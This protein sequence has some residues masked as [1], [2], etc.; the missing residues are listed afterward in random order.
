MFKLNIKSFSFIFSAMALILCL[1]NLMGYDD[2]NK[3]LLYCSPPLWLFKAGW[4]SD[5]IGSYKEMPLLLKYALTFTFWSL[6]G[7]RIDKAKKG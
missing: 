1:V 4:F 5:A 6:V 3:F 7:D 2:K